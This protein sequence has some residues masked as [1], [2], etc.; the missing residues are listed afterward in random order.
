MYCQEKP[1]IYDLLFDSAR[2]RDAKIIESALSES[3]PY[4]GTNRI[5]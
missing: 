5:K 4:A 1:S 2:R 3:L